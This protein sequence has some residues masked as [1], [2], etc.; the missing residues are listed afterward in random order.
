M[1]EETI[2]ATLPEECIRDWQNKIKVLTS[3]VWPTSINDSGIQ[4]WLEN[5]TGAVDDVQIER[6]HAYHLLHQF[7][8]FGNPEIRELLRSVYRDLFLHPLVQQIRS[9]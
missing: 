6:L 4:G 5:F 2:A 7:M 9:G 1:A 8:Y 3:T